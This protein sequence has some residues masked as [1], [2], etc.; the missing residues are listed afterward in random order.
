VEIVVGTSGRRRIAADG[1]APTALGITVG[2]DNPAL[3]GWADVWQS[4]LRALGSRADSKALRAVALCDRIKR[5]D[6][7]AKRVGNAEHLR[8]RRQVERYATSLEHLAVKD[9]VF[10]LTR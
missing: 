5:L 2:I 8:A 3:P 7:Y 9:L 10:F 6:E 1:A 4:A